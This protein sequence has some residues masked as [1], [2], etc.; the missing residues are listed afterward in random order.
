MFDCLFVFCLFV[1]ICAPVNLC[2]D[3]CIYARSY[4]CPHACVYGK[5]MRCAMQMWRCTLI[6]LRFL[7]NEAE[8]EYAL[9]IAHLILHMIHHLRFTYPYTKPAPHVRR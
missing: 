2:M 9:R 8:Y 1:C 7:N 4:V 6:I 3:V 5:W